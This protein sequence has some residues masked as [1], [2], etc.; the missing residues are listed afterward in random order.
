MEI[1]KGTF[2]FLVPPI[3]RYEGTLA[4]LLPPHRQGTA[5]KWIQF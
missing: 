5:A 4:R 3:H 1:M 2:D